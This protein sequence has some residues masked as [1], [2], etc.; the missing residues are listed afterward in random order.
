MLEHS[1][2]GFES[3]EAFVNDSS[4]PVKVLVYQKYD[5]DSDTKR[6]IGHI[7]NLERGNNLLIDGQD[8]LITTIPEDNKIY[9]K[10]DMKIC[11]SFFP[12]ITDKTRVL[13]RDANGNIVYDKV[14]DPV[15]TW[16]GG[17][18]FSIPCIVESSIKDK[19]SNNQ[20]NLPDGRLTVSMKYQAISN[21]KLNETF[22]M[23]SNTYKITHIDLTQVI[24]GIGI[25]VVTADIVPS[26]VIS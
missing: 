20:L 22:K 7:A 17:E 11:N 12:A 21:V 14:G 6:V 23:Y 9:R 25:M 16:M 19:E 5:S 26:E 2:N 18:S 24:N 4:A 8:W 13:K 10:A 1:L 15:Y 3:Y